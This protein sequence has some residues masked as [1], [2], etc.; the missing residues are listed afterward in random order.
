[1]PVGAEV[2]ETALWIGK[3]MHAWQRNSGKV[4]LVYR[5]NIKLHFCHS[6]RANDSNVRQALIDRFG[7]PG[8]KKNPGKLYGI[9]KDMWSALAIAIY[10]LDTKGVSI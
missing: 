1:M 7:K 9:H 5:Q 2:F 3:F 8:V 10:F 6:A 4:E